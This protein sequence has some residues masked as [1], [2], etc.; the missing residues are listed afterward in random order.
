M[1]PEL[2]DPAKKILEVVLNNKNPFNLYTSQIK[3]TLDKQGSVIDKNE[4]V[5]YLR[6]LENKGFVELSHTI[7][8]FEVKKK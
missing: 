2:S 4:I 8:I 6:E 7:R 1:N 3:K 5:R